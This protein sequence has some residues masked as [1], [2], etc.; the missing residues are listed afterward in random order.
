MS[1]L[2]FKRTSDNTNLNLKEKVFY[3]VK[4]NGS[5]VGYIKYI[6]TEG[7]FIVDLYTSKSIFKRSQLVNTLEAFKRLGPF[8]TP[9]EA[10]EYLTKNLFTILSNYKIIPIKSNETIKG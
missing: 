6:S 2:Y 4:Y 10:K 8:I 3:N 9:D 7:H 1:R 5:K